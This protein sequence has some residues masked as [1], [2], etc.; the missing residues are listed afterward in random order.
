MRL[1]EKNTVAKNTASGSVIAIMLLI[2][3]APK[4]RFFLQY[5]KDQT[6]KNNQEA[7]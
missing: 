4:K 1:S 7:Q 6:T 3:I 5:L 2:Q